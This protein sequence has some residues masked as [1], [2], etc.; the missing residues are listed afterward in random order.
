MF[1]RELEA[2]LKN[3]QRAKLME[4]S[5]RFYTLIP[6]NFGRQRPPPINTLEGVRQK[7][8]MLLVSFLLSYPEFD[9]SRYLFS[10]DVHFYTHE[11]H[12]SVFQVLG[13]IE[14]AQAIQKDDKADEDDVSL[15]YNF[16]NRWNFEYTYV[17]VTN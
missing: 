15:F 8:D 4:M 3:N 9:Y 5:S 14:I 7:K 12:V 2:A 11:S 10:K 17:P 1:W 6:H 16:F 13:D